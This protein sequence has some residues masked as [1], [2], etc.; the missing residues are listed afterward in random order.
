MLLRVHHL[1]VKSWKQVM[2]PVMIGASGILL[3][4]TAQRWGGITAIARFSSL[5]SGDRGHVLQLVDPGLSSGC[6]SNRKKHSICRSYN[7]HCG[8]G[9]HWLLPPWY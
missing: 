8:C 2:L 6:T 4:G 1:Q 5:A 7:D 9:G 3:A